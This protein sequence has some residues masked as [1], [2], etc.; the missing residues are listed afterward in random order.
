MDNST[1][2]ITTMG[3]ELTED[4]LKYLA[5]DLTMYKIGRWTYAV[6]QKVLVWTV[7]EDSKMRFRTD[8]EKDIYNIN[9]NEI[10]LLF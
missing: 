9:F 3:R 7:P 5:G 4:E 6:Y 2:G 8:R 1:G 10:F